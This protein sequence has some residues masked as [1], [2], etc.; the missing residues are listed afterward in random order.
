MARV[1]SGQPMPFGMAGGMPNMGGQQPFHD[2]SSNQSANGNMP[3]G[4]FPNL[5]GM[6]NQ[7]MNPAQA[8]QQRGNPLANLPH[9]RQLEMMMAHNNQNNPFAKFPQNQIPQRPDQPQQHPNQPPFL[10]PGMNHASPG[11]IFSPGMSNDIRRG[12]PS[13]PPHSM[14]GLPPNM[15]GSS[16]LAHAHERANQVRMSIQNDENMVNQLKLK[17]Q[18]I[19][20]ITEEDKVQ[21]AKL[22][23]V[24]NQKKEYLAKLVTMIQQG[25]S[26]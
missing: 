25:S 12:S 13:N 9:Q 14:P 24:V 11:D 26:M 22:M 3:G 20:T 2:P 8:Q 16:Q 5:G 7:G 21:H 19:G 4:G 15:A 23:S 10:S 1:A 17:A 18:R 6:I